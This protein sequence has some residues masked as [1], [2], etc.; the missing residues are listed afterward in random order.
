MQCWRTIRSAPQSLTCQALHAHAHTTPSLCKVLC[1]V[2]RSLYAD[3][4]LWCADA[5][6]LM[7]KVAAN[8]LEVSK[9]TIDVMMR[10][11]KGESV[12]WVP[13]AGGATAL[14]A[15]ATVLVY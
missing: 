2:L 13:G 1:K 14:R 7:Q 9:A 8:N 3:G 4:C 12:A 10:V 11:G 6:E 5:E 15:P